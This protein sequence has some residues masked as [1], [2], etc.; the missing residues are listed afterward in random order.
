MLLNRKKK[1]KNF[2]KL[3]MCTLLEEKSREKESNLRGHLLY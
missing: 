1:I 3:D 2:T